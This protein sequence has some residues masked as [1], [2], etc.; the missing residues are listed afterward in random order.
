ME[1][2][3]ASLILRKSDLPDG[4]VYDYTRELRPLVDDLS[5]FMSKPYGEVELIP[6]KVDL[7]RY[8]KQ[9]AAAVGESRWFTFTTPAVRV[10]P[11]IIHNQ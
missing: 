9:G 3:Y 5:R 4:W 11:Y 2:T 7:T 1:E 6:L 10:I 8:G